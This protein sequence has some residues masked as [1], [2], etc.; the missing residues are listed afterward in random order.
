MKT[1]YL[2]QGNNILLDHEAQTAERL[3]SER[4]G[5]DYIYVAKEPMHLV[6]GSGEEKQELYVEEG[7]IIITFYVKEFPHKVLVVNSKDWLENINE[8]NK[9]QQEDKEAWAKN[10]LSKDE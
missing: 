1:L 3:S 9:K 4:V 7:D 6:Y 10:K 2:T 8:Y 5:I